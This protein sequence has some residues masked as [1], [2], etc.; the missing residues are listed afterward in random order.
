LID[1]NALTPQILS[2]VGLN[3]NNAADRTLL[4]SP[5]NSPTAVARGFSA[6]PYAGFPLTTTV[7]QSLRP[8]PQFGSIQSL[9]SPDGKTWYNALQSKVTKRYSRGLTATAAFSWQKTLTL[10]S[11]TDPANLGLGSAVVNDVF[12]RQQNKYL[13]IFDQPMVLNFA[14]SYTVPAF[15]FGAGFAARTASWIVRDWNIAPYAQYASGLPI[16]APL[17]QNNLN[18]LLL[19]NATTL[20]FANRVPGMPLFTQNLNCHCFDPNKVFALNPAAWTQP[21]A[22]QWGSSAAYYSDYRYQRV[23]AENLGFGRTVRFKERF[24]LNVRADFINIFNRTRLNQP[25][26]TNALATQTRNAAGQPTAGF[27]WISTAF[28]ATGPSNVTQFQR[29]GTLVARVTF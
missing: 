4:T 22:G 24:S 3:L 12:N 17:A 23:P 29:T 5:L 21:A 18:S 15:K 14:I 7:A 6:P 27:G 10:A 1:I 13:S 20:S 28:G 16:E 9:W 11:E 2:S 19:R 25:V 26:S 8:F